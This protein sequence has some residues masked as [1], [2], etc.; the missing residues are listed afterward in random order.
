MSRGVTFLKTGIAYDHFHRVA[1]YCWGKLRMKVCL[2]MMMMINDL[3][4]IAARILVLVFAKCSL[5]SLG[6][7][8]RDWP[9]FFVVFLTPS[10]KIRDNGSIKPLPVLSKSRTHKSPVILIWFYVVWSTYWHQGKI[11]HK[12]EIVTSVKLDTITRE[13]YRFVALLEPA[14]YFTYLIC[15]GFLCVAVTWNPENIEIKYPV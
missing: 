1:K 5:G 13:N 4:N 2:M 6:R 12:K 9:R 10:K 14:C 3:F 15:T 7:N 11:N 8:Q